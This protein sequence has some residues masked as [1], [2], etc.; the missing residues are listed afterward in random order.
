MTSGFNRR[1]SSMFTFHQTQAQKQHGQ[2]A[3]VAKA[4][5]CGGGMG[6]GMV[7]NPANIARD[8]KPGVPVF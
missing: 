7:A 1:F 8:P 4:P 2:Q 5:V 6:M 3:V